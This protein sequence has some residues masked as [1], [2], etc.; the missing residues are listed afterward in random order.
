MWTSFKLL[1]LVPYGHQLLA[2]RS[3]DG[4]IETLEEHT[5]R[6]FDVLTELSKQKQLEDAVDR[7]IRDLHIYKNEKKTTGFS[8]KGQLLIKQMFS[9][10][11]QHHD[12]GKINPRFQKETL[13]NDWVS[14][15]KIPQITSMETYHAPLSAAIFL[16]YFYPIVKNIPNPTERQALFYVMNNFAYT[17]HHHHSSLEKQTQLFQG[18][19]F[20]GAFINKWNDTPYLSFYDKQKLTFHAGIGDMKFLLKQTQVK[21]DEFALY[22]L[23]HFLYSTIVTCDNIATSQFAL[24]IDQVVFDTGT[25]KNVDRLIEIIEK[26]DLY[27]GIMAYKKDKLY[28]TKPPH[29]IPINGLRSE[30]FLEASRRLDRF[31][32]ELMYKLEIPPGGGKTFLSLYLALKLLKS[33]NYSKIFYIFPYNTLAD[34]THQVIKNTFG[35]SLE[36][37]MVNSTSPILLREDESYEIDY[38]QS[39]FDHQL[40]NYPLVLTS[41]VRLFQMLFG[42]GRGNVLPLFQLANSVVILDEIQ[43]YDN[44]I[45]K[46]MMEMLRRYAYYFNIKL[47][48]M[49]A[50]MPDLDQLLDSTQPYFTNLIENPK[51]YA[52]DP[53][54]RDR[55]TYD[56]HL[57][58]FKMT[59]ERLMKEIDKAVKLRNKKIKKEGNQGFSKVLV[60]F[61]TKSSADKFYHE[62]I[63]SPMAKSYRI[64]EITGDDSVADRRKVF[65]I[66]DNDP[67]E[68][69][70][71]ITTQIIEAGV[72]ID[73]DIGFKD[74]S[75]LDNDEQFSARVNR[76]GK[77]KHC[78]V[79]YFKMDNEALVYEGDL[80]IGK[81]MSHD[82]EFERLKNKEFNMFYQDVFRKIQTK[83]DGFSNQNFEAFLKALQQLEYDTIKHH[84]SLI[85]EQSIDIFIPTIVAIEE[86]KKDGKKEIV[87]LDGKAIWEEYQYLLQDQ[88]LNYAEKSIKLNHL[89]Q[90]IDLFTYQ[91][92][93]RG[94]VGLE[95]IGCIYYIPDGERYIVNHRFQ[96]QDWLMDYSI[97]K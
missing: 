51:K 75:F 1:D 62:I 3:K 97:I 50:T 87:D 52:L 94:I 95:P 73:M 7:M 55:V 69:L 65:D 24:N 80:R 96:R 45:W 10:A 67:S 64:L 77:K 78:V 30:M 53:L 13:L 72:D 86:Q 5:N 90:K 31:L 41:H 11:V 36:I 82:D 81:N 43:T 89:R 15:Q 39:F 71:L 38:D 63:N 37:A 44:N 14:Q 16:D 58:K 49:S 34:Q 47:I 91:V 56:N 27:Q 28:F 4:R 33:G 92:N 88:S 79:Y 57:T 54:F 68:N 60:G 6:T 42:L 76:S 20:M 74:S 22:I 83:K 29:H 59:N 93:A 35:D 26:S 70:I 18:S 8:L 40:M 17:I 61:L 2:H 25:I 84:M 12:M 32:H 46:E 21:L 9:F 85:D 23:T 66:I 48:V 19:D